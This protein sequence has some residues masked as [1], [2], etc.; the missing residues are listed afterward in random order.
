[1]DEIQKELDNRAAIRLLGNIIG[2]DIIPSAEHTTGIDL[3]ITPPQSPYQ[4]LLVPR[5]PKTHEPR[6]NI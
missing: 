5:K 2:A 3:S 6:S 4:Y 1:M